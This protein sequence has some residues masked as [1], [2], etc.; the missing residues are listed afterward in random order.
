MKVKDY[1]LRSNTTEEMLLENKFVE[2]HDGLY[3]YHEPLYYFTNTKRPAIFLTISVLFGEEDT[4]M[5][6]SIMNHDG[7]TY[8]A[9]YTDRDRHDN[10]VCEEVIRNYHT[11]MDEL[12]EAK[13]LKVVRRKRWKT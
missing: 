6:Y 11:A 9:F 5:V 3:S 7:T 10:K 12:V 8:P 4:L 13:I 1:A 2:K